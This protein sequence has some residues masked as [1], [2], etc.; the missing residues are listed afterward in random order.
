MESQPSAEKNVSRI[1]NLPRVFLELV[2]PFVDVY[3]IFS[4]WTTGDIRLRKLLGDDGAVKTAKLNLQFQRKIAVPFEFFCSLRGLSTLHVGYHDPTIAFYRYYTETCDLSALPPTLTDLK[5]Q[6]LNPL[7]LFYNRHSLA[8][9]IEDI[10]KANG[11]SISR[12]C[13]FYISKYRRIGADFSKIFYDL[14]QLF[15]NLK[16][17]ALHS[18]VPDHRAMF[19]HHYP[20]FPEYHSRVLKSDIRKYSTPLVYH[21]YDSELK[22]VVEHDLSFSEAFIRSLPRQLAKLKL[23]FSWS[24]HYQTLTYLPE[25]IEDL[26]LHAVV[27]ATERKGLSKDKPKFSQSELDSLRTSQLLDPNKRPLAPSDID[28]S[29]YPNLP[30]SLRKLTIYSELSQKDTLML[31]QRIPAS[32]ERLKHSGDTIL[33]RDDNISLLPPNLQS[34]KLDLKHH[35][36]ICRVPAFLPRQLT[37]LCIKPSRIESPQGLIDL[38]EIQW[39]KTLTHLEFPVCGRQPLLVWSLSTMHHLQYLRLDGVSETLE[40]EG[41]QH[42]WVSA[43]LKS[44]ILVNC[45]FSEKDAT[46]LPPSLTRFVKLHATWPEVHNPMISSLSLPSSL[47]CLSFSCCQSHEAFDRT[48]VL[49][50][51]HPATLVTLKI[52]MHRVLCPPEPPFGKTQ[53]PLGNA[54]AKAISKRGNLEKKSL[55]TTFHLHT[56]QSPPALLYSLLPPSLTELSLRTLVNIEPLESVPLRDIDCPNLKTLQVFPCLDDL[57]FE[58]LPQGLTFLEARLQTTPSLSPVQYASLLP[59]S[60]TRLRLSS[61]AA[62]VS[63][64]NEVVP[65]LP[66]PLVELSLH[67]LAAIN[68]NDQWVQSMLP[69]Q[70]QSQ[71]Y[72]V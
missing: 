15:P 20:T 58:Y 63:W 35:Y 46:W 47:T 11:S 52:V 53:P 6:C 24:W 60:L 8:L 41:N 30:L 66:R 16:S 57:N 14:D 17:L 28:L 23:A 48:M 37:S 1:T 29:V 36:D 25:T 64:G 4:L 69:K 5:F 19:N 32:L 12:P 44:L 62:G 56:Q 71:E 13:K 54:F 50:K 26:R 51:H 65:H 33:L 70:L 39:P 2:L 45:V 61:P 18:I 40:F 3:D 72:R 31:L 10:P 34:L 21:D 9:T 49:L 68:Y 55:L 42:F 38:K 22:T 27:P 59:K 7:E 43:P 67:N